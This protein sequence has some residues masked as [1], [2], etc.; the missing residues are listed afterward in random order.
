MESILI[1]IIIS[2]ACFII[3]W[4][5]GKHQETMKRL[6]LV[7]ELQEEADRENDKDL[8][9]KLKIIAKFNYLK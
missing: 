6:D 8:S 7:G 1:A 3:G 5:I 4:R 9:V 2:V